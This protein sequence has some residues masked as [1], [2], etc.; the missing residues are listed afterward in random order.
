MSDD[1]DNGDEHERRQ[2]SSINNNLAARGR[3]IS[4]PNGSLSLSFPH[5]CKLVIMHALQRPPTS[6][7]AFVLV[8]VVS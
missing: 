7:A 4:S 5:L 6:L 3:E 1:D 8:L 2:S